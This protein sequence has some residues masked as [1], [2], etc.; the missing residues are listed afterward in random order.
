MEGQVLKKDMIFYNL[1]RKGAAFTFAANR[2]VT[3]EL[4]QQ[5]VDHLKYETEAPIQYV[6]ER[7]AK[8]RPIQ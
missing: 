8:P 7:R 1:G 4:I 3:P 2:Y 5:T 6:E